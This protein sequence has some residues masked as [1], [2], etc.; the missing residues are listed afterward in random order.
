LQVF[1]LIGTK[2]YIDGWVIVV[3]DIFSL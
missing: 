1:W 3:V 2:Y